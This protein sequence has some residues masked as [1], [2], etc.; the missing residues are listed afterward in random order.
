MQKKTKMFET[1][2]FNAQSLHFT[3]ILA[4]FEFWWFEKYFFELLN[5]GFLDS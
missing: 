5:I 1:E 3:L 4:L 2:N